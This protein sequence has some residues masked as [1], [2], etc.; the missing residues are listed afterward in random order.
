MIAGGYY[1]ELVP[2]QAT[3][4]V[5]FG[6]MEKYKALSGWTTFAGIKERPEEAETGT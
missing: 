3:L 4:Y 6:T 1:W 2:S 5:P